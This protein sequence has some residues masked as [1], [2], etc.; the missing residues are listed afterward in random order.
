MQK[1]VF[2][3]IDG[4]LIDAMDGKFDMSDRVKEAIRR[5]QREGHY[6]FIATGRPYAYLSEAIKNFG[7]DGM[8]IANG[9]QIILKDRTIFTADMDK[10]FIKKLTEEFEAHDIQYV[11]ECEDYSYA[12]QE[13]KEFYQFFEEINISPRWIKGSYDLDQLHVLK[14]ETICPN[15]EAAIH[16]ETLLKSNPE[17]DCFSS[18]AG[19]VYELYQKRYTKASA[20]IRVLDYLGLPLADSFAFGDGINDT[21]MLQAVGCGIAMGN[22]SDYVKSYADVITDD[23]REDGVATG[24]DRFVLK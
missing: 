19:K 17:F 21:D 7:F 13:Y 23:V 16:C 24:I 18:V 11:L 4:T 1:I 22:A 6:V 9:A 14:V 3:D 15:E 2:F 12:K 10:E 8:I 20:I 5:L